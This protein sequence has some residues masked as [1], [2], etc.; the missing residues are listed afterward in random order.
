M[1]YQIRHADET[2]VPFGDTEFRR[3]PIN[4]LE[5]LKN[6]SFVRNTRA[7][8][9]IISAAIILDV[10]AAILDRP[11]AV[12]GIA[13]ALAV[14]ATVSVVRVNA[15]RLIELANTVSPRKGEE[16][17]NQTDRSFVNYG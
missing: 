16:Q 1:P 2:L 12:V 3:C 5:L 17:S 10:V 7:F 15:D 11:V 6:R 9:W 13:L 4:G 14:V 8:K